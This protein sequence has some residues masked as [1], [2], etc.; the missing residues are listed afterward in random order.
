MP[1]PQCVKQALCQAPVLQMPDFWKD[2]VLCTDA[3]DL[4]ISP[5]LHQR[6]EGRLAPIAYYSQLLGPSEWRFS[7]YEKECLA[8]LFGCERCRC[9]LEHKEFELECDN[10][11]LCSLLRRTKDVGRLGRWML[12]LA[13]FKFKVRHTRGVDNVVADALSRMFEG[14][15]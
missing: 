10:L 14:D 13:P 6:V 8:V 9:Y 15:N 11:S 5:V 12:R 1:G 3:S 4:A 7:S 2:F